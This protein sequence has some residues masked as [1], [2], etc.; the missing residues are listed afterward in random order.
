MGEPTDADLV[1]AAR[2][3]DRAAFALLVERHYPLLVASCRRAL[4]DPAAD[5]AQ[6][7]V[8]HALLGLDGLRRPESFGPWLVGIGLNLARRALGRRTVPLDALGERPSG[9]PGPA[10]LAESALAAARVRSAIAVLPPGQRDAVTLF[11]LAGLS[12][13]EVAEHLASTHGAIKTRLHKARATLRA[14]LSDLREETMTRM[15]IA[16]VRDTRTGTL[17]DSHVVVLREEDGPR[18][19][20]IW[21]G[22]AEG[23]ALAMRLGD[24]ELPRPGTYELTGELLRAA[25]TS[26]SEVRIVRLTD[27]VFYAQVVLAGGAAV[28]ARPSDALNLALL[29]GAPILVENEVLERA[30]ATEARMAGELAEALASPRDAGVLAEEARALLAEQRRR[31]D[32]LRA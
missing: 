6:E 10:E 3:G 17:R 26:V 28:D 27:M 19:L 9:E 13:P 21:I 4:E 23:A 31:L 15:R 5:V 16:D 18:R 14:Q 24:V 8:V 12:A 29:T 1:V 30:A 25:G 7:A 2:A 22:A 11:Y 20:P 32:E